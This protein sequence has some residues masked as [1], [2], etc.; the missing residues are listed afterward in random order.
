MVD[1]NEKINKF[2]EVMRIIY[3]KFQPLIKVPAQNRTVFHLTAREVS[4]HLQDELHR[5]NLT[6]SK[7]IITKAKKALGIRS[8][9][10]GRGHQSY[11]I[12]KIPTHTPDQVIQLVANRRERAKE[13]RAAQPRNESKFQ[14]SLAQYMLSCGCEVKATEA[15]AVL[16]PHSRTLIHRLKR[17]LG[18]KSVKH[19]DNWY[20]VYPA[21]EVA[22]WLEEKLNG[23]PIPFEQ[24][25][26]EASEAGWS[27]DVLRY[28]RLK[29]GG[30][31]DRIIEGKRC[32]F[33]INQSPNLVEV[34]AA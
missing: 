29:M 4:Q 34:T 19:P 21:P 1:R 12:W 23:G 18:I 5:R 14:Q 28:T 22:L 10:F 3:E 8:R 7:D 17:D 26:E 6:I 32:W 20:W 2:H 13:E 15:L 25:V 31:S 30:I 11:W 27:R 33:D 9:K 16:R 24:L